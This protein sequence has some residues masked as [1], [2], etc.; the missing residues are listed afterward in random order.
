[1]ADS[2]MRMSIVTALDNAGI[3]ATQ[4]Q[5]DG[6]EKQI[7][8]INEKTKTD[9]LENA[10]GR[11][12][13]KLGGISKALGGV[14]GKLGLVAGA[15][16][17]GYELGTLF[18][19]K[20]QKGL[21]GWK[22]PLDQLVESNKKLK[23][24][25][26]A[27][28]EAWQRKSQQIQTYYATEQAAIDRTIA[29]INNQSQAYTRLAKASAEFFNAGEDKDIQMLERERFEDV[30][31]LQS[32]GEYDAAEQANKL[33][34]IFRQELE[35]KKQILAFDDETDI[36]EAEILKKQEKII[37]LLEKEKKLKEEQWTLQGWKD[38]LD[39]GLSNKEIDKNQTQIN[40]RLKQ[41]ER[42]LSQV[43]RE[44]N[45]LADDLDEGW[46]NQATRE[47]QRANLV[48]KLFLEGDKAAYEYDKSLA[49]S[50]NLL[51]IEF[52]KDFVEQFNKSSI[53]SYNELKSIE[54]NTQELAAKLDE[55][56]QLKQ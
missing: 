8:K 50:G 44:A 2:T 31:R 35:A 3:K 40:A 13:G 1:M 15:F 25:Q 41:I 17:T 48:D 30:L 56:L 28:V 52:T 26:D 55:L 27:E 5:I 12:P 43:E 20:V 10:L 21:F 36:R 29:K 18:F 37:P 38:D 16:T 22:D 54:L 6:L 7:N 39:A 14:V 45:T 33:Y 51:G 34:D 9:K 19:E 47:V 23:K 49:S 24:W 42:E 11:M 4:D 46:V 32:M 53:D